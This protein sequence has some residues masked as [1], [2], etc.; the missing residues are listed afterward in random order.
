MERILN[1]IFGTN[2]TIKEY[3][4]INNLPVYMSINRKFYK[5]IE[6]DICFIVV[7]IENS[8][9]GLKELIIQ[10]D[11]YESEFSKPV[12]FYFNNVSK[13]Q[14][15]S[16]IRNRIPFMTKSSQIYIPFIGMHINSILS[17]EKNINKEKMMPVSQCLFLYMLYIS[18]DS[19]VIK[20][21]VAEYLKISK[22]SI[23]RASEQLEAM[24]IICQEKIGKEIYMYTKKIGRELF[25]SAKQYLINPIQEIVT[26]TNTK[27]LNNLP[28]SNESALSSIAMLNNPRIKSVAIY[29][30]KARE[31]K[32]NVIDNKWENNDN[33]INV[34]KWKYDPCLFSKNSIVDPVSLYMSLNA[35]KDERI[36]A[37][38]ERMIENNL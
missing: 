21:D 2:F 25:E 13:H 26:V 28:L 24:N 31:Y 19:K 34:E 4:Q 22:M 16:L 5:V 12:V 8:I 9:L 3:K 29:K 23:T 10:K 1:D 18:K 37:E 20:K 27:Q 35:N 32:F 38:I 36:E 6:D 7:E 14:R 17:N 33:V 11:K 15:D 30:A